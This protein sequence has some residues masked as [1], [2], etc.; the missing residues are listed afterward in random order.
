VES[1]QTAS[2]HYRKRS[3][4]LR[5]GTERFGGN[6]EY[7]CFGWGYSIGAAVADPSRL[8]VNCHGDG[9]AGFHIQELDT[10]ARFGLSILT[11]VGNNSAWGMSINGQDLLYENQTAVRPAA[12]LSRRCAYEVV[13][14]GFNCA[15]KKMDRFE[16][17]IRALSR[18]GPA[19]ANVV[20][21]VKPTTPATLGMVG[22][23]EDPN[24]SVN[25]TLFAMA[26]CC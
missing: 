22:M 21:S 25:S 23:T 15:S 24:V 26:S 17:L 14:R 18:A 20:V 4:R 9:S 5:S 7:T 16:D 3:W 13:A 1:R 11:V 10:R 6:H 8:I 19:L 2:H 12:R